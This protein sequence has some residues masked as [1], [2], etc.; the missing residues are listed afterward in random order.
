M[1]V[2]VFAVLWYAYFPTGLTKILANTQSTV[3]GFCSIGRKIRRRICT[4][5]SV[6]YRLKKRYTLFYVRKEEIAR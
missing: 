4:K 2:A 6:R 5:I 1:A 3:Y